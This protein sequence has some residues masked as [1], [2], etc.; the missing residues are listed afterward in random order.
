MAD[1]KIGRGLSIPT[2]FVTETT[3]I[4]GVRSSG[5]TYTA[6]V[7]VEE[8]ALQDLPV[9]VVDPLGV[10]WGLRSSASGTEAGY[11]FIVLGGD[12]GDVP[13][14]DTAGEVIAEFVIDNAGFVILDLSGFRKAEMRRFMAAFLAAIYHHN[15][16]PLHLVL[17]E[18][19][20]FAPQKPAKDETTLLGTME[21]LIRRGRAKGLGATLITQ[22]PAVINKDVLTQISTLVCHRLLG[23]TDRTAVDTW[24]SAHGSKEQRDEMMASLASLPTGT[25]YFWSPSWLGIFQKVEVRRART[26]DSSQTP[27]RGGKRPEPRR[28]AEVDLELLSKRM[29][30]TIE[31]AKENDPKHLRGEVARLKKELANHRC[32]EVAEVEPEVVVQEVV[33][34]WVPALA[35]QMK[36]FRDRFSKMASAVQEEYAAL[37]PVVDNLVVLSEKEPA[38]GTPKRTMQRTSEGTKQAPKSPPPQVRAPARMDTPVDYKGDIEINSTERDILRAMAQNPGGVL[39]GRLCILIGKSWTGTMRTYLSHLRST[40]CIVGD[41]SSVMLITTLG[42]EVLGPYDPLPTGSALREHW[43]TNGIIT[44]THKELFKVILDAY[45]DR[46]S[47]EEATDQIGKQWS[48]TIRT[49][50]SKLRTLGVIEGANASMRASEHLFD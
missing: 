33:P 22:R 8:L 37:L 39:K 40:G 7:I 1:L 17:D 32:P 5:K 30:D 6:K 47:G 15:R 3:G 48:G 12:H 25:A 9:C 4:I 41:N 14:K 36:G 20:L 44:G 31:K 50:L 46:I 49:Y 13:L 27:G 23:P 18:A 19:D 21:D 29:E 11:P 38:K 26:F 42:L 24:V 28:R 34:D 43:L 45:P 10:W 16:H 2:D 35:G